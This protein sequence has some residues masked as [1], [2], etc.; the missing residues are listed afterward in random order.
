[1]SRAGEIR[2]RIDGNRKER[3]KE[4]KKERRDNMF[5]KSYK[6]PLPSPTVSHGLAPWGHDP[7]MQ[8]DRSIPMSA[9]MHAR[10]LAALSLSSLPLPRNVL[11]LS[12]CRSLADCLSF[13]RTYTLSLLPRRVAA[14]A[15]NVSS[16]LHD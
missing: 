3:E 9:F 4:R 15:T 1:M 11:V 2:R 13:S 7:A 14:A 10:A 8:V 12:L 5:L 6:P 16:G